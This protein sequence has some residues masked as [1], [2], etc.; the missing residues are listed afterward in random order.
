MPTSPY[1]P[2]RPPYHAASHDS[3]HY[4]IRS[5]CVPFVLPSVSPTSISISPYVSAHRRSYLACQTIVAVVA[6]SQLA[7]YPALWALFVCC[8][9]IHTCRPL[10]SMYI[11]TR[12]CVPPSSTSSCMPCYGS[13]TW[14]TTRIIMSYS[15]QCICSGAQGTS[16]NQNVVM[17]ASSRAKLGVSHIKYCLISRCSAVHEAVVYI[18]SGRVHRR[19]QSTRP[20]MSTG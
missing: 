19:G 11:T 7:L 6:L 3:S 4:L 14:Q 12:T 10:L 8:D 18:A 2:S 9:P 1:I 17:Y 5:H 13:W 15:A 20:P 16:A